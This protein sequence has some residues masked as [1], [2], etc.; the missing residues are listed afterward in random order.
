MGDE[1]SARD[2][3][4]GGCRQVLELHLIGGELVLAGD[5]REAKSF[6]AGISQLVT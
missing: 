6:A 1:L 3:L 5:H 2:D 4:F